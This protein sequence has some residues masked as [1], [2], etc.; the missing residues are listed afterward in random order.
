MADAK[1]RTMRAELAAIDASILENET[2]NSESLTYEEWEVNRVKLEVLKRERHD[3]NLR[4]QE[5]VARLSGRSYVFGRYVERVKSYADVDDDDDDDDDDD[6]TPETVLVPSHPVHVGTH[7]RYL[8][9]SDDVSIG[10]LDFTTAAVFTSDVLR[11][12]ARTA[13]GYLWFATDEDV[14]FP[15]SLIV[16]TNP[17]S[18]QITFY[19]EGVVPVMFAGVDY[20]L[21]VNP[22]LLNPARLVGATITLG[23][24]AS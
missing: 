7:R 22:N 20:V 3:L 21:G 17:V 5:R 15:D 16:S 19:R 14:G 11:V 4:I 6:T 2:D 23:Y 10:A 13:N 1:L 9:W 24:A 12:P 18:N 8:G